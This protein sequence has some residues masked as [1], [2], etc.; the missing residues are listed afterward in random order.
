MMKHLVLTCAMLIGISSVSAQSN[1]NDLLAA[2][3]DRKQIGID[4]PE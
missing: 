2:G 3:L 1:I 4:A